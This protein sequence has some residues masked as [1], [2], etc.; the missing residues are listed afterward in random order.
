M[1]KLVMGKRAAL[2]AGEQF[3]KIETVNKLHNEI[4]ICFVRFK[5]VNAYDIGVRQKTSRPRFC[6]RFINR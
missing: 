4:C 1:G 2:Y 5:I 6:E 3:R